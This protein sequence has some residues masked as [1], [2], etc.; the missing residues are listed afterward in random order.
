MTGQ[1]L[2]ISMCFRFGY[3]EADWRRTFDALLTW[4]PDLRPTHV[5]RRG[6]PDASPDEPWDPEM[7]AELARRCVRDRS[8]S[9]GLDHR[10]PTTAALVVGCGFHQADLL[11]AIDRPRGDLVE[12][13]ADL[14]TRIG[15]GAAQPALAFLYDR[16]SDHPDFGTQGLHRLDRLSPLLYLDQQAV[17]DLG[18]SRIEDAPCR[19]EAMPHGGVLLVISDPFAVEREGS[20]YDNDVAAVERALGLHVDP[21]LSLLHKH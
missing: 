11:I 1:V 10:G 7:W 6:E 18:A 16:D 8:W 15:D 12:R 5:D 14:L 17:A 9:W 2:C 4:E 19:V 3:D 21:P 20:T 13:F